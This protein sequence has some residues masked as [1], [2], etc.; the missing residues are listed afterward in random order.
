[1]N[2][3]ISHCYPGRKRCIAVSK[4]QDGEADDAENQQK[5]DWENERDL[6]EI[7]AGFV[8]R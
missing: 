1:M 5:K 7:T 2:H 8:S 6:N 4:E 3:G